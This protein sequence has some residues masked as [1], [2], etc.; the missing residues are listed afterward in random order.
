MTKQF[1]FTCHEK[2]RWNV[3]RR[4][5]NEDFTKLRFIYLLENKIFFEDGKVFIPKKQRISKVSYCNL[6]L[7]ISLTKKQFSNNFIT[8]IWKKEPIRLLN[9]N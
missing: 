5:K 1:Y 8:F 7:F 2:H 4:K 3:Q 6:Y 9:Y